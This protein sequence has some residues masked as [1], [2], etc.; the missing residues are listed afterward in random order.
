M[1]KSNVF[2]LDANVLI[3]LTTSDHSLHGRAMKWFRD[4]PLFATCPVTQ[5]ALVRFQMR[6]GVN[7]SVQTAKAILQRIDLHARHE[8]WVDDA[9]YLELPENGV[10]GH[11]QI[12]DAYLV[13]L[14]RKHGG[15][16]ATMD[17]ALAAIHKGVALI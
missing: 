5:G 17:E 11:R 16:L 4:G 13:L 6:W 10:V 1:T 14:A 7:P 15:I 9:S 3:A 8:F 2:L 12:T